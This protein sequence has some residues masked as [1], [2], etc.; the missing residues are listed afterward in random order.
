LHGLQQYFC[1]LDEADKT[2]KLCEML[3]QL[4]FNQVRTRRC[5]FVFV[6][7]SFVFVYGMATKKKN[8]CE[9][10]PTGRSSCFCVLDLAVR[11]CCLQVM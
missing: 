3:D 10:L 7:F 5:F 1:A 6:S 4:D 9:Q 11:R 8:F 2:A